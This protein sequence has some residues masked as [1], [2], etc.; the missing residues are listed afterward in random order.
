MVAANEGSDEIA[1][2]PLVGRDG[3]WA[4]VGWGPRGGGGLSF[5]ESPHNELSD[6]VDGDVSW[7]DSTMHVASAVCV[8][9]G[10]ANLNGQVE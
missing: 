6:G 5:A 2:L 9:Q 7:A 4:G 8:S 3:C 10:V 1:K